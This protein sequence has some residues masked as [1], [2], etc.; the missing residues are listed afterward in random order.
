MLGRSIFTLKHVFGHCT[1]KSQPIWIKFCTH[2]LFYRIHLWADLDHDQHVGDSR[3]NQN[4]YVFVIL[5]MHPKSYI[6]KTDTAISAANRQSG[7]EDGCYREKFW[8]FIAQEEPDAKNSIFRVFR[9]PF[10]YPAYSLQET[11]LPQTNCT[12]GQ[13]RLRRCAFC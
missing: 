3:P 11:V 13:P 7:G 2:L 5:V 8:N 9:V 10:D 1:A 12:N 6:E 4:H